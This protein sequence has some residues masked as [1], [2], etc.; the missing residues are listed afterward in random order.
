[1][2]RAARTC[3]AILCSLILCAPTSVFAQAVLSA[4]HEGEVAALLAPFADGEVVAAD[5]RISGIRLNAAQIVIVLRSPSGATGEVVVT[6]SPA[7]DGSLAIVLQAASNPA[8]HEAQLT[9]QQHLGQRRF[10]AFAAPPPAPVQRPLAFSPPPAFAWPMPVGVTV[11]AAVVLWLVLALTLL[12]HARRLLA[13]TPLRRPLLLAAPLLFAGALWLRLA[14]PF[15]PLHSNG[16]WAHDA[17]LALRLGG[18]AANDEAAYG[19]AWVVVQQLGVQVLGLHIAGLGQVAAVLGALAVVVTFAAALVRTRS[20]PWALAGAGILACAPIAVRIGHSESPFIVAQLLFAIVLLLA[21]LP[22]DRWRQT[23]LAAALALIALGHPLGAGY[24]LAALLLALAF[25]PSATWQSWLLPTLLPFF[26]ALAQ[27]ALAATTLTRHL[28]GGWHDLVRFGSRM[29]LWT[30]AVWLPSPAVLL[31]VLGILA[32]A[33]LWQAQRQ[34]WRIGALL[35]GLAVLARTSTLALACMTDGLRY[36]APWMPLLAV[37]AASAG[38]LLPQLP[39]RLQRAARIAT[40]GL[41]L[42]VPAQ[43]LVQPIG[44]MQLDSQ[45]Q[46]WRFLNARWPGNPA[47]PLHFLTLPSPT[48]SLFLQG[49]PVGRWQSAG[50]VSDVIGVDVARALCE[51]N[52]QLPDETWLLLEPGCANS[53]T[54]NCQAMAPWLGETV[55]R[56]T[57]DK[58]PQG[59]E[60]VRGEFLDLPTGSLALAIAR[61]RCPGGKAA[62]APATS[63]GQ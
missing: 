42:W 52:G 27:I 8:L 63:P 36:Q 35:L 55:V 19:T 59:R 54:G 14:V 16:H 15:W 60:G 43:L 47:R 24:A 56:G 9:L 7:A 31:V 18:V 34:G 26:A 39:L 29:L 20:V 33:R 25:A 17:G 12:V 1:M 22:A 13:Q 4:G 58:L 50:P 49:P 53:L 37:L 46:M 51:R 11:Y 21:Q 57:V 44:L 62:A 32:T 6:P 23:G 5:V 3:G 48:G 45:G 10:A 38:L 61:A 30:S 28:G 40:L 41:L 2:G